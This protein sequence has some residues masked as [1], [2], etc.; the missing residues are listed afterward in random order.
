MRVS[1]SVVFGRSDPPRAGFPH[2]QGLEE[3]EFH[4][5]H[6][7]ESCWKVLERGRPTRH[8]PPELDRFDLVLVDECHLIG[9]SETGMYRS[10]LADAKV[11]NRALRVVGL[12]ATPFR[13]K[14]GPICSPDGF[15]DQICYEIGV[16]ELI[17]AG[18]LCPLKTKSTR[19]KVDT[20]G[21]HVRAGEFIPSEAQDLMDTA[22]LVR[23]A[24]EE[25]ME[26]TRDRHSCLIF[27]SGVEH[28]R[29]V[30]DALSVEHGVD[31]ESVFGETPSDERDAVLGRF[32]AGDLPYLVNMNVL[33]TGFDAPNIDTIGM[34]RPT[35][36][37]G[38]Y[39]QM[40]GRGFRTDPSKE[41]CLV[42]DFGG[43]VIRHG[44]VDQVRINPTGNG[45]GPA[46][47]KECP[48]CRAVIAM[49]YAACPECGYEFPPSEKRREPKHDSAASTEDILSRRTSVSE[50]TVQDT[51]YGVHQKRGAS[52]D[53][54]RTMRVEYQIGW[55]HWQ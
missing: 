41:D 31:C 5:A 10:F 12:T 33:T 34:L 28:G 54:P 4:A 55:N 2:P 16:K 15:L 42:L 14:S 51:A 20:S 3:N 17:V 39:Y 49:G 29:H 8:Q 30:R 26:Y 44:P 32:R 37:P 43:N 13:M 47:A 21:L 46:P 25:I 36:S 53:H 9:E 6:L 48:K 19:Q 40:V 38:L 1:D 52:P 27:A 50:Y 45:D 23:A 35:L 7:G 22:E 24:C 11:I 18:Y